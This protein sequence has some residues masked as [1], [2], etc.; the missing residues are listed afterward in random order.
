MLE[1]IEQRHLQQL[2]EGIA[3]PS[4]LQQRHTDCGNF[5][6]PAEAGIDSAVETMPWPAWLT[7]AIGAALVGSRL[8]PRKPPPINNRLDL[9]LGGIS[10]SK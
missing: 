2:R 9:N 10:L 3:L 5:M 4:C 8:L 6:T 1:Q 7:I